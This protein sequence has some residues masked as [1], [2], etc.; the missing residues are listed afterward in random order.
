MRLVLDTSAIIYLVEKRVD[1]AA[2]MEFELFVPTAVLEEL[3]VLSRRSKKARVALELLRFLKYRVYDAPGPADFAAL[4]AAKELG[5]ALLTGD[6][7]LAEAARRGGVPVAR[8]HK[9][10]VVL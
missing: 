9:K 5:A 7:K 1:P 8:F 10:Q 4:R 2:L 6:N 3:Q